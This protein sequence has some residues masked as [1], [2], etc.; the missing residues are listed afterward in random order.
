M[1]N[2]LKHL[3]SR[4]KDGANRQQRSF[5]RLVII[6]A[7]GLVLFMCVKKDGVFRLIDAEHNIYIQQ[8]E[9]EENERRIREAHEHMDA[10][11]GNIDS[12][13]RFARERF[14]FSAPGEDVYITTENE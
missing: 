7:A 11:R 2:L 13:E 3:W 8:K 1:G 9:I 4:S 14:Y 12:L 10:L 6:G 5:V